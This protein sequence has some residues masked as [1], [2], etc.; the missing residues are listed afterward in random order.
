MRDGEGKRRK[1]GS[2]STL[3]L[4]G[5]ARTFVSTSNHELVG[6]AAASEGFE[7]W[8]NTRR[9]SNPM[10]EIAEEGKWKSVM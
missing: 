8:R 5:G 6:R 9:L 10:P 4:G 3:A 7:M 2:D 1:K